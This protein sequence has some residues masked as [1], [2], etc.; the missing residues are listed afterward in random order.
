[1][2]AELA[3]VTLE[4]KMD[5]SAAVVDDDEPNFHDL[6]AITLDNAGIDPQEGLQA[7]RAAAAAA[8]P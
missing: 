4:D 1:M 6:A 3:G 2:A 5:D 7:A 8:V